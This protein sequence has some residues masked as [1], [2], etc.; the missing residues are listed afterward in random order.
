MAAI[1]HPARAF[2]HRP[3][4]TQIDK[5]RHPRSDLLVRQPIEKWSEV[6]EHE[7]SKRETTL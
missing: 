6:E 5:Q 1:E 4:V 3:A 7:K 2:V